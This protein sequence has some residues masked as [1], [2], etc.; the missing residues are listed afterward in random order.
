MTTDPA[1]RPTEGRGVR[2]EA[3]NQGCLVL[4]ITELRFVRAPIAHPWSHRPSVLSWVLAEP[5]AEA[6]VVGVDVV[7]L[8]GRARLQTVLGSL[9][10]VPV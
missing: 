8:V 5:G 4:P 9:E 10:K 7:V 2:A 3:L 6:L 1:T